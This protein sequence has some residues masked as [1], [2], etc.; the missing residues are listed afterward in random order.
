MV[1]SDWMLGPTLVLLGQGGCRSFEVT[2]TPSPV[3]FPLNFSF[4]KH[5]LNK[6]LFFLMSLYFH[7]KGQEWSKTIYRDHICHLLVGFSF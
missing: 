6:L 1:H 4:W 7:H 2:P 3:P 5:E